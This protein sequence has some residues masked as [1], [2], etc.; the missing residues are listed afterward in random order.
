MCGRRDDLAGLVD[1]CDLDSSTKSGIEP[2][3]SPRPGG[4]REQK[5]AQIAGKDFDRLVFRQPKQ[6]GARRST[7]RCTR[8]WSATPT[9][10]YSAS[11][12]SP[13]RPR[14]SVRKRRAI[15]AL[16]DP[17]R[18]VPARESVSEIEQ[19][20]LFAAKKRQYPVRRQFHQWLR[21]IEIVREFRARR[22]F[23][24]R[25]FDFS[26]PVSPELVTQRPMNSPSSA[27]R[28]TR[29]DRAPS[30]A[31][32]TVATFLSRRRMAPPALDLLA[33]PEERRRADR[34]RF[35]RYLRLGAAFRLEGE[36]Y[37]LQPGLVVCL[38][39][40]TLRARRRSLPCPGIDSRI[41]LRPLIEFPQVS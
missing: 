28:S 38:I 21:E 11:Q 10:R 14:S 1:D 4:R 7:P 26:A 2:Q 40:R 13:G 34:D 32:S 12:R 33:L 24:L 6:L 27:K 25:T 36:I 39:D 30:S 17:R 35:A 18:R 5:I 8:S 23:P 19:F 29:M 9:G 41:A 22:S 31:A 20:F 37:I 15:A 16:V 3:C